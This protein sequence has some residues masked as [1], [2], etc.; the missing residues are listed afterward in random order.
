[1][2]SWCVW[3]RSASSVVSSGISPGTGI[4][5]ETWTRGRTKRSRACTK[6][7]DEDGCGVIGVMA[8]GDVDGAEKNGSN[9]SNGKQAKWGMG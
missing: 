1:M 4:A 5:R 7:V 8:V 9:G 2:K 3:G 6:A